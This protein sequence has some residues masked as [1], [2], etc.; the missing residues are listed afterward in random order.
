MAI[1]SALPRRARQISTAI[2]ML[3][4]HAAA[5]ICCQPASVNSPCTHE[6][7]TTNR[8]QQMINAD[9]IRRGFNFRLRHIS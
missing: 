2:T 1:G 9:G 6:P 3:H 5:A 8:Q 4:T 7:P